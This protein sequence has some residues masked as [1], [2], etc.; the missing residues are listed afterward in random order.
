[1]P[2]EQDRADEGGKDDLVFTTEVDTAGM[3][4]GRNKGLEGKESMLTDR[5][6]STKMSEF[7]A[8]S[9][10]A[11][12]NDEIFEQKE[13]AEFKDVL[14]ELISKEQAS[15]VNLE[16]KILAKMRKKNLSRGWDRPSGIK[17]AP[18]KLLAQINK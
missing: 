16:E 4:F 1:V 2:Q 6:G 18:L 11:N 10:P 5:V 12:V 8:L 17:V 9:I 7:E 13:M 14:K 15:A 3:D